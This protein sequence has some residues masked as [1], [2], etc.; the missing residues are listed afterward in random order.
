MAAVPV[1]CS[2]VALAEFRCQLRIVLIVPA[3]IS[4]EI[5]EAGLVILSVKQ[6][7]SVLGAVNQ[8]VPVFSLKSKHS[9]F[10]LIHRTVFFLA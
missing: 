8:C 4:A 3:V 5:C 2:T 7:A 9:H 10:R 1:D 6:R